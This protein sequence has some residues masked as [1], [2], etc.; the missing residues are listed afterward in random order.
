MGRCRLQHQP[1][2]AHV[3]KGDLHQGVAPH[4]LDGQDHSPAK[5]LVVD[6]VAL[7]EL[8][9]GGCALQGATTRRPNR[10]GMSLGAGRTIGDASV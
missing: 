7:G 4:G 2:G 6:R 8:E 10:G 9:G 1:L 5:G 3:V